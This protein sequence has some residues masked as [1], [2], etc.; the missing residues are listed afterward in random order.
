M[1][2]APSYA[3]YVANGGTLPEGSFN[4]ALP[5]AVAAVDAAIWP[6]VVTD[7]TTAAYQRAVCAVVDETDS[8]SVISEGVG[9]TSVTYSEA[10]T[11][12]S[13]IRTHLTGTG[14]LYRG[15]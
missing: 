4:A 9:R 15:V 11:V 5:A 14:L 3:T 12:G 6:N 7:A 1:A 2:Q 8:P 13:V 10:P